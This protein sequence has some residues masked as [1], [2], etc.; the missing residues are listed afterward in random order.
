[1]KWTCAGLPLVHGTNALYE[2]DLSI[3]AEPRN[4]A[5]QSIGPRVTAP[6]NMH[7]IW[8][9]RSSSPGG[10]SELL[11]GASMAPPIED[12][13]T[14]VSDRAC[15][16]RAIAAPRGESGGGRGDIESSVSS[17]FKRAAVVAARSA[18]S[19]KSGCAKPLEN[20]TTERSRGIG[21][22]HATSSLG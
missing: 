6:A 11:C 13:A 18:A 8:P 9:A 5:A 7:P 15:A 4:A 12:D 20:G 2:V 10:N 17:K 16:A 19:A 14:G 1:M 22:F 21:P 3:A